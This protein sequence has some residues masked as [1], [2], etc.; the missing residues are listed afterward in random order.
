MTQYMFMLETTTKAPASGANT[1]VCA[2]LNGVI[3][4]VATILKIIQWVVPVILIVLGTFD[5][6]KAVMA[7][8]EDDIKKNQ[9]VLIKRVIAAVIVFLVPTIVSILM[10]LIG[11]DD[12][13]DC[14]KTH[15]SDPIGN[16]FNMT[17]D[18]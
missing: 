16:L 2:S 15:K 17:S 18:L 10:G 13:K 9:K 1:D 7:G 3:A 12:W 11:N 14:W 8:K 4:I 6:V 5:L